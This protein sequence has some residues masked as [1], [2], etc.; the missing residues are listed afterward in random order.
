M[1]ILFVVENSLNEQVRNKRCHLPYKGFISLL[2][3]LISHYYED[4]NPMDEN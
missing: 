1:T 2:F 3:L 4:C